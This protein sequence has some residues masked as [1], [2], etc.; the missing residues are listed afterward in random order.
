MNRLWITYEKGI[1]LGQKGSEN[2]VILKDEEYA[3]SCR[4]TLERCTGNCAI[5]CG[6]YGSMVHTAFCDETSSLC[7]Y[8]KMK[9]DLKSFIDSDLSE[10]DELFFYEHFTSKY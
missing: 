10:E 9:A 3:N 1:T 7:I 2:G 5:T 4:I 8:E 6:I